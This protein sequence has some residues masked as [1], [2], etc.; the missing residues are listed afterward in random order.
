[1][2]HESSPKKNP[3]WM[4]IPRTGTGATRAS[5]THSEVM[6]SKFT[7]SDESSSHQPSSAA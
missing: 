5:S 1:M 6:S 2:V 7:A 3:S 4:G